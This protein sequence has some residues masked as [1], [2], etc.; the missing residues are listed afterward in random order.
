M[1]DM[2]DW[3]LAHQIGLQSYVLLAGLGIVGV[4]ETFLP[5]RPFAVPAGP[6]WFH[7]VVL[8][9][10]GAIAIRLCLPLAGVALAVL[11]EQRGW[12]LLNRIAL[13]AW[14]TVVLGIVALDFANYAQHRLSHAVP[15]L[16][17]FHQIHHS[18]LD[19]DCGTSIRHHPVEALVSHACVLAVI[20][21]V[22]V[23]PV[24]AVLGLTLGLAASVFNHGNIALPHRVDAAFR[25]LVV[26][27]DMH[28]IHHSVSVFESNRNFANLLPWWDHLFSTYRHEPSLGQ[29]RMVVGLS[30]ARA[31]RDVTLWKLLALPFSALPLDTNAEAR[32]EHVEATA[33]S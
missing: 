7:Q 28:R 22:G 19:V 18:D 32:V 11:A 20:A 25:F 9:A 13:P 21:A 6:R 33:G 1:T 23:S 15:L 4:W 14:L 31:V 3:L 29:Q 27:P 10:L 30:T 2:T 26:T 8:V 12:G 24:A 5:R 17:R 16:W